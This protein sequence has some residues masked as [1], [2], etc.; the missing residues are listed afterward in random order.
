[1]RWP[2]EGM[3]GGPNKRQVAYDDL[4]LPQWVAG[5][6]YNTVQIS[7]VEKMKQ[8]LFQVI[9]AM[10]DASSLPWPTVRW[11]TSMHEIEEGRLDWSQTTEWSINR[12]NSSQSSL[13]NVQAVQ[14]TQNSRLRPCRYYNDGV[15]SHEADHGIYKHICSSCWKRN[16]SATHP[17][18]KCNNKLA[19]GQPRPTE[20]KPINSNK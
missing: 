9:H 13:L 5:Q 15:C 17:E 10:R 12:L 16:R 8:V 20:S 14:K 18:T 2:N 6:L 1:M 11:A 19:H 3:V 7:D 4:T